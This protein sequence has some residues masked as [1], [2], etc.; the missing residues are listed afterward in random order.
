MNG[1]LA[2]QELVARMLFAGDA[3]DWTGVRAAF[4]DEVEVDYTS[5]FGGSPERLPRMS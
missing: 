3:L 2:I 5:L 4:A 1:P